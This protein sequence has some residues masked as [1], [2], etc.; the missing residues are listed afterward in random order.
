M[1][2]FPL[3]SPFIPCTPLIPTPFHPDSIDADG[4]IAFFRKTKKGQLPVVDA[5]GNLTGLFTR[6][7]L[8]K[9][10]SMPSA[11]GPPSLSARDGKLLVGA[12]I[13]TRESDKERLAQLVYVGDTQRVRLV[14]VLGRHHQIVVLHDAPS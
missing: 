14:I 8:I 13:G 3:H 10:R 1:V 4:A 6:D 5:A 9:R 12:A 11:G 2:A 7:R